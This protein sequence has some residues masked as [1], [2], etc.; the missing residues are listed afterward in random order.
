MRKIAIQNLSDQ[1]TIN[2]RITGDIERGTV[3]RSE[4]SAPM[5]IKTTELRVSGG[6]VD[7][8][9]IHPDLLALI[10]V[11]AF[12][13]VLPQDRFNL[14]F[15]FPISENVTAAFVQPH[16]VPAA[17][18]TGSAA[19][20]PYSPP[21]KTVLSYGGGIDSLAAHMLVPDAPLVH[22]TPMQ[23][24]GKEYRDVVNDIMPTLTGRHHSIADNLR[25][26]YSIW[27]LPLWV[28]VYVASLVTQ[29]RYIM[30][31]SEMTGTY[32]NGGKGYF[33]RYANRWYDV[34]RKIGVDVLPTSF[35]SEIGNARIVH[36]A[37]RIGDA[38]YCA[39]IRQKDCNQCSKCLRR[40]AIRA[41]L[42]ETESH[43][44]EGFKRTDAI[45]TFMSKRPLY[46]GDIFTHALAAT[47]K[48]TWLHEHAADLIERHGP[49]SFHESYYPAT[50]DHFQYPFEIREA[51]ERKL[52][53]FGVAPFSAEQEVGFREYQ[54]LG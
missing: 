44:V 6:G 5:S 45:D 7:Y 14:H 53:G 15:D 47:K 8:S 48:R 30:S 46:Y 26:L 20:S 22:E 1:R 27:G 33:P 54:Q 51:V 43:L 40:R 49:I 41:M 9:R 23:E 29:P 38:A 24:E 4:G 31:G 37:G 36:K 17:L 19:G 25:S 42:D 21:E 16:I 32:L 35:L 28:S 18:I 3:I 12:H 11:L 2:I 13:P 52:E 34:F 39:F 50:F 10:A